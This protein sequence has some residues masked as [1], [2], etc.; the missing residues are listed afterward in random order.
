ML[1]EDLGNI[2]YQKYINYMYRKIT[3]H[4]KPDGV[5]KAITAV[6]VRTYCQIPSG[7]TCEVEV[8]DRQR[9]M[10][11]ADGCLML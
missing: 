8:E 1:S 11:F 6:T 9:W 5:C 7:P 4:S 3:E 10:S 2:I